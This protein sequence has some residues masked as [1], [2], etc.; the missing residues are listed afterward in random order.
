MHLSL[1]RFSA[2][3]CRSLDPSGARLPRCIPPEGAAAACTLRTPPK[4]ATETSFLAFTSRPAVR[5]DCAIVVG[6]DGPAIRPVRNARGYVGGPCRSEKE[7]LGWRGVACALLYPLSFSL[8]G[9]FDRVSGTGR[10]RAGPGTSREAHDR[11]LRGIY[12]VAAVFAA[13]YARCRLPI[14]P[15][16]RAQRCVQRYVPRFSDDVAV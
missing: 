7:V 12:A 13:V 11:A 4:P 6:A 14:L 3:Q 16:C 5:T 9:S 8:W 2:G 15:P 1:A 10:Q